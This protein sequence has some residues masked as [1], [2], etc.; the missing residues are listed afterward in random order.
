MTQFRS[1]ATAALL[2]VTALTLSA[3]SVSAAAPCRNAKGQFTKCVGSSASAAPR[4]AATR[5]VA[6]RP[7]ATST[8]KA[9]TVRTAA[10]KTARKTAAPVH[11]T[12]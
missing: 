6:M 2:G 1:L 4:K 3:T 9:K 5:T 7:A 8:V 10:A 12:G 11:T